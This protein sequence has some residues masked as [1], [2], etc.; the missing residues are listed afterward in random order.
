VRGSVLRDSTGAPVQMRGSGV[1]IT[2]RIELEARY[3]QAQKMESVGRLAGGVAHDFNNLL[4]VI[5]GTIDLTLEQ[6]DAAAPTAGLLREGRRAAERATALTRQLL[7]FSRR[8]ITQPEIL[9]LGAMVREVSDML[10]RLIGEHVRLTVVAADALWP[11]RADR[12]QLEQVIMNLAVNARDAMPEGGGLAIEISNVELDELAASQ[13]PPLQAGAFVQLAVTDTGIGMEAAV[14]ER[15][16]EPFYTTKE[17]G[18]GTGLGLSTVYSIIEQNRGG[19]WVYSEPG[20]GTTFKIYLPRSLAARPAGAAEPVVVAMTGTETLL[21]V[22]DDD[23]LRE[24]ATSVLRSAGY[25]VLAAA[26]GAA[27]LEIAAQHQGSLQL[28]LT[29]MVMPGMG[30]RELATRLTEIRPDIRIV[31]TSGYTDDAILRRHALEASDH[32]LSK[33]YTVVELTRRI[34]KVLDA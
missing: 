6:M 4:T 24:I 32:F 28:V 19:I 12:G 29:D 17:V 2:D 27:A 18:R 15:I 5:L 22:E 13:H 21:V 11:V 34:R 1:D 16:F 3:L 9:D 31:Y 10:Q 30:G 33:P 26:S 14:R 20:H 8:Q 7:A 25:T 23:A